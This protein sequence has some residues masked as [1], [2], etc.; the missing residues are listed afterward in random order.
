ML[1]MYDKVSGV[2]DWINSKLVYDTAD[3]TVFFFFF[4]GLE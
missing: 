3:S 4:L 2:S 1:N